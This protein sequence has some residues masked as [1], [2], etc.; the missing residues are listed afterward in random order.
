MKKINKISIAKKVLKA[1]ATSLIKIT[2]K[3]N[4][5]F[6][7]ACD[8]I[9]N[10]K[11]KVVTIGLGKSGHV[12]AKSS[13][14]LSSTGTPSIFVHASEALH[15]DMGVI[16]KTDIVIFYSNSGETKELL[17]LLPLLKL[18]KVPLITITGSKN[19]SLAKSSHIVLDA[20]V[21]AEACPLNLTPS[22]S[23]ITA[24]GISDALA[25]TLLE[26]RGFTSKDF[27]KSHPK[28]ELGKRL[29][30]KVEDI[31]YIKKLPCINYDVKLMKAIDIITKFNYGIVIALNKNK[32]VLGVFTD[33]D[34]RRTLKI[35]NDIVSLNLYK[36]MTKKPIT[37]DKDMMAVEAMNIM[38]KKEITSLVV[39][40]KDKTFAGLLTLNELLRTGIE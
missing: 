29:L 12:A 7:K 40:D 5:S 15:G 1:E 35:H 28:G 23:V 38:E 33:G 20:G 10:C 9:L 13:A 17:L 37:I 30:K 21:K 36:V 32:K 31:M 19:S 22:S 8:L 6:D 26:C 25:I 14:T 34:L 39:L 3:L 2:N 16:R 24:I 4:N 11:G 18:L 27:A